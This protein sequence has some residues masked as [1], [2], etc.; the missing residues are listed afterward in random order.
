MLFFVFLSVAILYQKELISS[1][2]TADDSGS[3][4]S[5]IVLARAALSLVPE[6]PLLG[7]GLNNYKLSAPHHGLASYLD[8]R[9]VTVVHN[10]FL[11]ILSETGFLGLMAFVWFLASLIIQ[12]WK[13][14]S[15]AT[16][17]VQWMTAVG[18]LGAFVALGLH[19]L[20]DYTLISS[21]GVF[22]EFWLLAALTASLTSVSQPGRLT[23]V[24]H[25]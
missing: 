2:L 9:E 17:S 25:P 3:A 8:G 16:S 13:N 14:V 21:Q 5:R 23:E 22:T 12:S 24:D 7:A 19:S 6:N 10:V 11:L 1:R 4:A 15:R 18:L 20:F